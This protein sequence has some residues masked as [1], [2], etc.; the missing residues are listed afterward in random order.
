MEE[1]ATIAK[2][3]S[4]AGQQIDALVGKSV[5]VKVGGSTL[6]SHDTAIED[7]VTL[8]KLGIKVALVHGGGSAISTW[9]QTV[10]K[11]P[12]F[13]D[14]LRVTDA[15]TMEIVLMV[16]A[17]KVNKELVASL[18]KLGGRAVGVSGLDG[19]LIKARQINEDLGLVGEITAMDLSL[20]DSFFA[21]GYIPVVAPVGVGDRGESLNIN[22]DTAAAEVAV[23]LKAE[24]IFFLT[25]VVGICD[26][27]KTLLPRLTMSQ[28]QGLIATGVIT[29]GMIPKAQACF[30]ALDGVNGAH[31]IDGRGAHALLREL[32]TDQ[33][34]GTT[35]VR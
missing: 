35:I 16:L 29:A 12:Q 23:A 22:A 26:H 27:D 11:K 32:L 18:N 14:G 28:T 20:L 15:E 2:L 24:S 7:I 10:G 19:G 5:V 1:H 13:I 17:G 6:G 25:D 3:L 21:L 9:L 30:R 8:S 4:N 33:Y 34:A 31:I